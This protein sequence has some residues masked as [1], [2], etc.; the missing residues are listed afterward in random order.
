MA[1]EWTCPR[2]RAQRAPCP[3]RRA[4]PL[5]RKDSTVQAVLLSPAS[6][7]PDVAFQQ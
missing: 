6:L 5:C 2:G 3:G 7:D 1:L 4:G